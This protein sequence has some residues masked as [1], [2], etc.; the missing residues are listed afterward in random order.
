MSFLPV[1]SA[2]EFKE[3]EGGLELRFS[4]SVLFMTS[5]LPGLSCSFSSNFEDCKLFRSELDVESTLS[6]ESLKPCAAKCEMSCSSRVEEELLAGGL[7]Y[8]LSCED[9]P[10]LLLSQSC[11]ALKP[12]LVNMGNNDEYSLND[13][14]KKI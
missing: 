4:A 10:P 13:I 8:S 12:N 1:M 3:G 2:L 14:N 11:M 5:L 6:D 9:L 7:S